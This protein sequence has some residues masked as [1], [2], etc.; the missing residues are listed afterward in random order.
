MA[1]KLREFS[2][3]KLDWGN[4]EFK[5][6]TLSSEKECIV[7]IP[8]YKKNPTNIEKASYFQ[9]LSVLS[10][11]Y[12]IALLHGK[13]LDVSNYKVDG[14]PVS[15][16]I[17]E[18]IFFSSRACYSDMLEF[19]QFYELFNGYKYILLYQLDAWIFE[20]RVKFFTKLDYDFIGSIHLFSGGNGFSV[21]NGGFSLRKVSSFIRVC[22]EENGAIIPQKFPEDLAFS[23]S[24]S[25]KLKIAPINIGIQFG[26]QN[27]PEKL[28]E[29]NGNKL[30]MGCHAF[31]KCNFAWW[32]KFIKIDDVLKFGIYARDAALFRRA[33]TW[34]AQ[35]GVNL[36]APK[37]ICDKLSWLKIYDCSPVKTMCADKI[38]VHE[39]CKKK[40]GEDIC[41][42][43]LKVYDKPEDINFDELPKQFVLKCNHGSGYNII[44]KDK[45]R[46]NKASIVSKLN[47]WLKKDYALD[48]W[49]EMHYHYIDK[50]CYAE[51]YLG[52]GVND[53]PDY[54]ILC[55]NGE[56]IMIQVISDRFHPDRKHANIY[57]PDWQKWD[58]GW[59]TYKSDY[60][61]PDKK[62]ENLDKMLS[63]ARKLS[64]D[65]KFVRVDF[66]TLEGKLYL[67]EL[68]FAPDAG[69]MRCRD[70]KT[71]IE[72]GNMLNLA[73]QPAKKEKRGVVYTCITGGYESLAPLSVKNDNFDYICYTDKDVK[74]DFWEVRQIPEKIKNLD[75]K[76]INRYIKTH[77]HEFFQSYD[78]SIYIDGNVDIKKDLNS[79][80]DNYCQRSKGVIFAGQ[81]PARKCIYKEAE[82]VVHIK[83]DTSNNVTPQMEKYK[84][85]GFPKEYGLTQN[86]I[87]IRY[88]NDEACKRVMETW[89]K[90]ISTESYRDQLSLFYS[91]WKNKDAKYTILDKSL[92]DGPVFVWEKSHKKNR[93]RTTVVKNTSSTIS[94]SENTQSS[95]APNQSFIFGDSLASGKEIKAPVK[96]KP[97]PVKFVGRHRPRTKSMKAILSL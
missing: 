3:K 58:I 8:I 74:S 41:V 78:L 82:A 21:G 9:V 2:G 44:V 6:N 1:R 92:F 26:F 45:S 33:E 56:P 4:A 71:E 23:V 77:P 87:L 27:M 60:S 18:D 22:G 72:I 32:K 42:P 54:K 30:P 24:L 95:A 64:E 75:N 36:A 15:E 89:W 5:H 13:S 68:T 83:K 86:C 85:E 73:N 57:T 25:E 96:Y 62:P 76:R 52:D 59:H 67:G 43:I 20:D 46:E 28:Y 50:K 31:E 34:T 65:F 37:T 51:H 38:K 12:E 79:F 53:V 81:H 48:Y 39:Y 47:S 17:C 7:V 93:T 66:Y 69:F 29:K 40:L 49:Y 16:I 90:E 19:R 14:V 61:R 10:K 63:Y 84:K 80:V 97:Q 35:R 11:N 70:R 55:C 94:N 88:H 91:L